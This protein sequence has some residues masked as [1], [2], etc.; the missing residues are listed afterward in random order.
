MVSCRILRSDSACALPL[1][2]AS[3]SAKF[4][5]RT[6]NQSHAEIAPINP[7]GA[8]PVPSERLEPE[9][10][11][12]GTAGFDDEH[13]RVPDHLTG[14]ELSDSIDDCPLVEGREKRTS[15]PASGRFPHGSH[16]P[17][18]YEM[19]NDRTKAQE[20]GGN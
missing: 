8:S 12:K 17:A 10:G 19:L 1:P 5:K 6:V 11:G 2:S 4:A 9:Q 15:L 20:P 13:D 14:I 3:A 16:T 7:A 18:K